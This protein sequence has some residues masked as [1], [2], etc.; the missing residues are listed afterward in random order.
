MEKAKKGRKA[1]KY[2]HKKKT[3]YDAKR[4]DKKAENGTGN[5]KKKI[6]KKR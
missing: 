3:K 6:A 4:G 1:T 2:D 5:R